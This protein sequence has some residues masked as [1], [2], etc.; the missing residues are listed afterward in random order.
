MSYNNKKGVIGLAL[1]NRVKV[2]TAID[3]DI[4]EELKAY[5]KE[6]EIPMSKLLDRCIKELLNK[7]KNNPS[8]K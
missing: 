7:Q 3:K 1:K 5:S 8:A 6:T 2:G 4:Y